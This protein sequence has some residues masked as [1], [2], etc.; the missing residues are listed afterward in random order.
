MH[1]IPVESYWK[2]LSKINDSNKL[3]EDA[4]QLQIQHKTKNEV[5]VRSDVVMFFEQDDV[6][7]IEPGIK[8][9]ITKKKVK[10]QKRTLMGNLKSFHKMFG[11]EYGAILP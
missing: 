3:I 5:K 1:K 9:C 7:R 6:S 2:R 11:V 10:K 8:D 4:L